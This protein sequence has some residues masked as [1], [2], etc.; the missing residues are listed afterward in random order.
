MNLLN[1][2]LDIE[3]KGGVL[4]PLSH[5]SSPK[6][7]EKKSHILMNPLDI[8]FHEV[9]FWKLEKQTSYKAYSLDNFFNEFEV[10]KTL[11]STKT[12]PTEFSLCQWNA[13]SIQSKEKLD[14]IENLPG[15]LILLQ[16]IWHRSSN[17][18]G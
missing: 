6:I 12:H 14:F 18:K 8:G 1:V 3:S 16:E 13:R 11:N 4:P 9:H 7:D 15:S 10:N 5:G 17:I 2:N